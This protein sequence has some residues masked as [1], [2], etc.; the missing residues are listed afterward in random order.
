MN[1]YGWMRGKGKKKKGEGWLT[2]PKKIKRNGTA[3][4]V[5][6]VKGKIRLVGV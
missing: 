1:G 5:F 4:V 3:T 2:K 6:M